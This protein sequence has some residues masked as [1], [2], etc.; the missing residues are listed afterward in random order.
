MIVLH[1]SSQGSMLQEVSVGS[2][3]LCRVEKST[4]YKAIRTISSL[5]GDQGRDDLCI[6]L[7]TNE[8]IILRSVN[9]GNIMRDETVM[10]SVAKGLV[11]TPWIEVVELPG[12]KFIDGQGGL[13]EPSKYIVFGLSTKGS[14][15]ANDRLLTRNCTSFLVTSAHLIF[16][17]T[18]HLLKFVHIAD[19]EGRRP[20]TVFYV[21]Y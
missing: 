10:I 7:E 12:K 19:V 16:T 1:S 17:T 18:Q 15:Y 2:E 21:L 6:L 9:T 4:V 3:S 13:P 20:R 5:T 8:V 11:P 14:L